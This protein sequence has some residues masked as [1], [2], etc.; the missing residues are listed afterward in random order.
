MAHSEESSTES[1][2]D[3]YGIEEKS[4][5]ERLMEHKTDYLFIL[6]PVIAFT[7]FFYYPIARGIWLTLHRVN[8]G[9][10]NIWVGLQNYQWL[11]TNDL[12]V[13]ALGW[14]V[15]FV[16]LSTFFQLSFG[17]L[18]ALL[19]NELR[20]ARERW[21]TATLMAPYFSAP[22]VG[23]IIW[24]W[25]LNPN[26]GFV[27]RIFMLLGLEPI[28]FLSGNFWPY[29]SL[30]VAQSWHDYAYAG[31]IYAAALKSIPSSQYEA[32]AMN[33][34]G[35][36]RRFFDITL[37]HLKIPTVIILAIRTAWNFA[38]FAQPFVLTGGGPGT[39]TMLLSILVYRVAF[40]R[41]QFGR[42]YAIGIVMLAISILAAVL[43]I[44]LIGEEEDMYL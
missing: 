35:R 12:F 26:Y 43:Y 41:T 20:G 18:L 30:I 38:E 32:A 14:S 34:A 19:L 5:V 16:G 11:L 36:L 24:L 44:T 10:A 17:M 9:G 1:F 31:I 6:L 29:V 15:V 8:L 28:Q 40:L 3:K 2:R 21:A 25:F 22:L 13:F 42:A 39:R 27:A 4:L 37:P 23:G 33:G 7:V